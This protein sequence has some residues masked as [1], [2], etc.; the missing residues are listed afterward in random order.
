MKTIY[1]CRRRLDQVSTKGMIHINTE[2]SEI[3]DYICLLFYEIDEHMYHVK[4]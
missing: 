3:D 2:F 1:I 4:L